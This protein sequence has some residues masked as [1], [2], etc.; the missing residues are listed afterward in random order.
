MNLIKIT[1]LNTPVTELKGTPGMAHLLVST[2]SVAI[3]ITYPVKTIDDVCVLIKGNDQS[4][5]IL[6]GYV[7]AMYDLLDALTDADYFKE[8]CSLTLMG[9]NDETFQ[10]IFNT[11]RNSHE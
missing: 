6:E 8:K 2:D 1:T 10:I 5:Y 4:Y 11:K 3:P 9:E 7:T